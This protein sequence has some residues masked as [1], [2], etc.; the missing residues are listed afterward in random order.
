MIDMKKNL[1]IQC[2]AGLLVITL[3]ACSN[4]E[5]DN[6]L[7]PDQAIMDI[8]SHILAGDWIISSFVESGMDETSQFSE[9]TFGFAE[10]GVI[11]AS[12][13]TDMLTGAWTI[14]EDDNSTEDPLDDTVDFTLFFGVPD[15]DPFD[16]LNED[17]EV[18]SYTSTQIT[19]RDGE[20][21]NFDTLIFSR[22]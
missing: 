16:D 11:S 22:N 10:G 3:I 17:W 15:T 6:A 12:S 9:F 8:E 13:A 20:N 5:D 14:E 1:L 4:D 7:D 19:L 2:L 18:V 21:G